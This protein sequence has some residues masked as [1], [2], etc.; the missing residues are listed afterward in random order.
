MKCDDKV[1]ASDAHV[2]LSILGSRRFVLL[3]DADRAAVAL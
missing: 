2:V 1:L 3:S